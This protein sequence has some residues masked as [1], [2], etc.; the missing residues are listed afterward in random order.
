[1]AHQGVQ[2]AHQGVQM[3]HQGVQMAHHPPRRWRTTPPQMAHP[4]HQLTV[5]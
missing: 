2:M 4:N 5:I 1:M 3:A